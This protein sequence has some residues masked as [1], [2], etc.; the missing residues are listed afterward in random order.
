[1]VGASVR[2]SAACG[3]EEEEEEGRVG[4]DECMPLLTTCLLVTLCCV[5]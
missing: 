1:V 2:V 5:G 3:A 4:G